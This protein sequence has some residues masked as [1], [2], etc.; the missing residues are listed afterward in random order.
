M[1][2]TLSRRNHFVSRQVGSTICGF[3]LYVTL[4][5]LLFKFIPFWHVNSDRMTM[6]IGFWLEDAISSLIQ[7]YQH[8]KH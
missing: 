8:L 7:D 4:R 3:M 1:F 2:R 6:K 5:V